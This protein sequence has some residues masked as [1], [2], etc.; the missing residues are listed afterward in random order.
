MSEAIPARQK[1]AAGKRFL[2]LLVAFSFLMPLALETSVEAAEIK[3]DT[4]SSNSFKFRENLETGSDQEMVKGL[5]FFT[6]NETSFWLNPCQLYDNT[7][8][9]ASMTGQ[10][11]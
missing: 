7:T 11:V 1:K 10:S 6:D 5:D 9:S 2:F 4:K 8:V 3:T